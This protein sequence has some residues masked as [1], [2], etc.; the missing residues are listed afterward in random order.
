[1]ALIAENLT[2]ERRGEKK[3]LLK[4]KYSLKFILQTVQGQD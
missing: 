1:M 4:F 2:I 3:N